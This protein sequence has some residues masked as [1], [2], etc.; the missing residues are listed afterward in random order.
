MPLL[1]LLT[2]LVGDDVPTRLLILGGVLRLNQLFS[3]ARQVAAA[4]LGSPSWY[5]GAVDFLRATSDPHA[6]QYRGRWESSRSM[7]HYMQIGAAAPLWGGI[8]ASHTWPPLFSTWLSAAPDALCGPWDRTVNKG[9][10]HCQVT[11]RDWS[12]DSHLATWHSKAM[13]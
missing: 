5:V 11:A 10:T 7:F 3:H 8:V 12:E 1:K 2:W 13:H 6:L 9:S 4:T